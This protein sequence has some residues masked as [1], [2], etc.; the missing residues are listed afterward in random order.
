MA[1]RLLKLLALLSL[2][3]CV[4]AAKMWVIDRQPSV[5][6]CVVPTG[7]AAGTTVLAVT[8]HDGQLTCGVFRHY[9]QTAK[10]DF[11]WGPDHEGGILHAFA[12]L[13]L[14]DHGGIWP[15]LGGFGATV[16]DNGPGDVWFNA[17]S[18]VLVPTW[19]AVLTLWLLPAAKAF[20]LIRRRRRVARGH[21]IRCGYD[22]RATPDN[23]PECG[24]PVE[25][26]GGR[27]A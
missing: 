20:G 5:V 17:A 23:C 2:L 14:S 1:R 16:F 24:T 10:P 9:S 27:A 8:H 4:A 11:Y 21:C 12:L 26:P 25:T 6:F 3:L 13:M 15:H 19:F 22:L 7:R 18:I